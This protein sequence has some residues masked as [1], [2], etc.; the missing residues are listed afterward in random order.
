M[1]D[2]CSVIHYVG[3][4]HAGKEK[5]HS[6]EN[7]KAPGIHMPYEEQEEE[8]RKRYEQHRGPIGSNSLLASVVVIH[9]LLHLVQGVVVTPGWSPDW[10]VKSSE[11]PKTGS[12]WCPSEAPTVVQGSS[13]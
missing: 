6:T 1:D 4:E 12:S 11:Y 7:V 9:G 8:S 13:G 3:E 10:V 5:E 2:E